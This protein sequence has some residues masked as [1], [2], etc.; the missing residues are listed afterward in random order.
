MSNNQ[1]VIKAV[2]AAWEHE[3]RIN[4]H[5]HPL[6]ISYQNQVL[7]VEGEVQDIAAKKL[8]MELAIA[9]PGVTGIVDRLHVTP[10]VRVG[11]GAILAAV[12]DVLLQEPALQDSAVRVRNKGRVEMIRESVV[13]NSGVIELSVNDGVVLLDDHVPSL[14]QKRLAGVLAW[15]VPGSRDVINGMAV[16][17]Y[18]ED[19]DEELLDA[20]RLVLEKDPFV[21]ADQIRVSAK[22]SMITLEGLVIND[23]QRRMAENDAW[24]VFGVD[25]VTNK[26]Q[27]Q[28]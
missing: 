3:P 4:L 15:W 5:T 23:V 12:R 2:Q 11:D 16:E 28:S 14:T 9:V 25:K 22:H 18:E 17:P 19:N 24:Y 21:N 1:N 13:L 20:V 7:T 10:A 27:I 8:C 26:L 6:T